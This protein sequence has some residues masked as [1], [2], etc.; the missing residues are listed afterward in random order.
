MKKHTG[1]ITVLVILLL[2]FLSFAQ[3][4]NAE[5]IHGKEM[6]DHL[7][8]VDD[9]YGRYFLGVEKL[10]TA[11]IEQ[12]NEYRM[13][14]VVT[15]PSFSRPFV[16]TVLQNENDSKNRIALTYSKEKNIAK[17]KNKH[18]E[19]EYREINTNTGAILNSIF[20]EILIETK[21]SKYNKH[22]F[23]LDGTI[24]QFYVNGTKY[25]HMFGETWSPRIG[26]L[27]K[28]LV[29]VSN[30]MHKYVKKEI[31]QAVFSDHLK[32]IQIQ[33]EKKKQE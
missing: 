27:P 3:E 19:T 8:P 16:L 13:L 15:Y 32:N 6:A 25:G 12:D 2:P 23:G 17:G 5:F 1:S 18:I 28:L 10:T 24:Y 7:W 21:Y 33:I 14:E 30:L 26:I 29:D 22:S 20:E 4:P 11:N 9:R 31:D